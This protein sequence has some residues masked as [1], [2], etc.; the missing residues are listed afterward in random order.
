[1]GLAQLE[2]DTSEIEM[3]TRLVR[4]HEVEVERALQQLSEAEGQDAT[5]IRV[6]KQL[7]R[8]LEVLRDLLL[9]LGG[10]RKD[11]AGGRA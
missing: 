10:A 6:S 1:M 11:A 7:A 8:E 9:K 3:L 5:M 2:L 4:A